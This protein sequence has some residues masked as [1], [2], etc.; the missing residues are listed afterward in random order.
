[1]SDLRKVAREIFHEA[2]EACSLEHA[3]AAKVRSL[4]HDVL[5]LEGGREIDLSGIRRVIVIAMGKGAT[6]M[7]RGLLA[8]R[9]VWQG[10]E[11]GGVLIAP[12]QPEDLPEN[13]VYFAGGH[14]LPNAASMESARTVLKLLHET[15]NDGLAAETFCFFLISGGASAMMELPQDESITLDDLIGLNRALVHSGASITEINCIRKHFSAVKGGRLALA[16]GSLPTMTFAVSDVPA[17][18]LDVLASGPTLPDTSTVEE[19]R[20]LIE[21]YDLLAQFPERVRE[22]FTSERL[23]ES[24]KEEDVETRIYPLLSSDDL[25]LAAKRGAEARGFT[26][27]IDNS[28]D[29]WECTRAAD[30][31]L[32]HAR[33]LQREHE[34]LCLIT[35]GE[36][37]VKLPAAAGAGAGGRNSHFALYSALTMGEDDGFTVLSAGSDGIDGNSP[38]AGAVVDRATVAESRDEAIAALERFDSYGYLGERGAAI[39]TGP[40]GNNL[41][42]LRLVMV[43]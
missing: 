8:Y 13:F 17:G 7:L 19:C 22:F 36:V 4:S 16:A 14:P 3:F 12:Q 41:R 29:D 20:E 11:V 42:D 15:S 9:D 33:K 31:L 5:A 30:Y 37:T 43:G 18:Q 32:D 2:L 39:V 27:V 6:T 35:A 21:K 10:R 1:M 38:A 26:A 28:C 40:S 24:P 23:V 34:R 25:A